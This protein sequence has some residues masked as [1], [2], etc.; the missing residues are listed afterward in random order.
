MAALND[1]EQGGMTC[2]NGVNDVSA[3]EI[4]EATSDFAAGN[5]VLNHLNS[6]L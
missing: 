2:V 1:Y 4:Q 6:E 5:A 3:S